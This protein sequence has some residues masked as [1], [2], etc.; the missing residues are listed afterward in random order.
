MAMCLKRSQGN[1]KRLRAKRAEGPVQNRRRGEGL[2]EPGKSESSRGATSSSLTKAS[3]KR[4]IV[5][6]TNH[7]TT[8]AT[9]LFR[10]L[11]RQTNT[12]TQIL[13]LHRVLQTTKKGMKMRVPTMQ[14]EILF[15]MDQMMGSIIRHKTTDRLALERRVKYSCWHSVSSEGSRWSH[16]PYRHI[17][18]IVVL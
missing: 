8:T 18:S 9:T 11:P 6:P 4:K 12:P 3:M 15:S 10:G 7:N 16:L 1:Q 17:G 13:K 14:I 2:M 5:P